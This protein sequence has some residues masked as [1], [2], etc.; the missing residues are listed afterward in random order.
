GAFIENP[1]K[2]KEIAK[3]SNEVEVTILRRKYRK[4]AYIKDTIIEILD[5][6]E[7]K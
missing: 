5:I 3:Q 1:K 6:I 4:G 7:S 2:L